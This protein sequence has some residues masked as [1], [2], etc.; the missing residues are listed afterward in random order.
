MKHTRARWLLLTAVWLGSSPGYAEAP[1]NLAAITNEE[2]CRSVGLAVDGPALLQ[3]FRQRMPAADDLKSIGPLV[4]R[5]GSAEFKVREDS[6][7]KLIG[8]GPAAL[9]QLRQVAKEGA[10]EQAKRAERCIQE[11][12]KATQSVPAAARLLKL[13]KPDGACAVLLKYL[14][15]VDDA[16]AEEAILDAL[17]TLGFRNGAIDP[18]LTAA[19]KD[20]TAYR[21]AAAALVIGCSGTMEQ[22]RIVGNLLNDADAQVR[23]R[24]AQGL[25]AARQTLAVPTLIALLPE[26]YLPLAIQAEDLLRRVAGDNAEIPRLGETDDLRR[27]CAAAWETWW[28]ANEKKLDLA[29][30]DVSQPTT[31]P[32]RRASE[33]ALRFVYALRDGDRAKACQLSDVPF[34]VAGTLTISSRAELEELYKD[35]RQ[36]AQKRTPLIERVGSLEEYAQACGESVEDVVDKKNQAGMRVVYV[37]TKEGR[38]VDRSVL[39]V[40]INGTQVRVVGIGHHPSTKKR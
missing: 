18:E 21:R 23:L 26:A 1:D 6:A 4:E 24:A 13:R 33:T 36:P 17:L 25:I 5:L 32:T 11:I 12:G 14:S 37:S 9:P 29:A 16:D 38:E 30:V 3:F 8:I 20:K 10:L 28:R 7:T 34:T 39:L 22:R 19:I 35:V 2:Q 40:R 27:K 31:G 15:V